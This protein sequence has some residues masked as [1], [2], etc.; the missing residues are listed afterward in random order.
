VRTADEALKANGLD[1][2]RLL[3]ICHHVATHQLRRQP[4]ASEQLHQ[5]LVSFLV[6]QGIVLA[7]K[8][9]AQ[10]SKPDYSFPSYLWD[11]LARRTTDFYRRKSEGFGDRRNGNDNRVV[12]KDDP[13]RDLRDEPVLDDALMP[14]DAFA[15]EIDAGDAWTIDHL[16]GP[17]ALGWRLS[18]AA[19]AAGVSLDRAKRHLD[20]LQD[21]LA[22]RWPTPSGPPE[23][24]S[25]AKPT[26]VEERLSV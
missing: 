22:D 23:R 9:D 14:F 1:G 12:L 18:E 26:K 20:E 19:D 6:E 17:V 21:A 5:D 7:L 8:Y 13:A 11:V 25:R 4:F 10:Q 24:W 2:E 16:A 3:G 15:N